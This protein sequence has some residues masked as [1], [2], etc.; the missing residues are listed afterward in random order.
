MRDAALPGLM[1][2]VSIPICIADVRTLR[3]PNM[4][5][6]AAAVIVV[7]VAVA[8]R[9]PLGAAT[10]AAYVAGVLALAR[11][12]TRG[13]L[14][15]GDVKYGAVIGSATGPTLAPAVL[16]AAVAAAAAALWRNGGRKCPFAP[17][18]AGAAGAALLLELVLQL[19]ERVGGLR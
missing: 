7:P 11:L 2:L 5:V 10:G 8:V 16:L 6:I 12:V 15:G 13:A 1:V 14:G 18:L 3:I 17:A 19:I 4:M 9:G